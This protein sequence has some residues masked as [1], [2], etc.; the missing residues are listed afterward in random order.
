MQIH[1]R[2]EPADK[3]FFGGP[4]AWAVVGVPLAGVALLIVF[5][6]VGLN[7]F[8]AVS[9]VLFLVVFTVSWLKSRTHGWRRALREVAV[10]AVP[11]Y[12]I[13]ISIGWSGLS[14]GGSGDS[15]S[16]GS[17]ALATIAMSGAFLLFGMGRTTRVQR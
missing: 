17:L 10:A 9:G 6:L 13:F 7:P 11:A 3:G 4:P 8:A 5:K 12:L 14:L 15:W 16:Y 1:T 2:Q